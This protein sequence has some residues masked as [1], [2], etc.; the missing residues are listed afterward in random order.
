MVVVCCPFL[1]FAVSGLLVGAFV[2][3]YRCCFC[4]GVCVVIVQ[5]FVGVCLCCSLGCYCCCLCL[6]VVHPI[7]V[8]CFFLLF[9]GCCFAV[10]MVGEE[11]TREKWSL[12]LL[13]VYVC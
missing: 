6:F 4:A 2:F 9:V 8:G 11:S 1:L 7:C 13:V 12:M 10:V 5:F 3:V